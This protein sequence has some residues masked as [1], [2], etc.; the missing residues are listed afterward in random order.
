MIRRSVSCNLYKHLLISAVRHWWLCSASFW[1]QWWHL[2]SKRYLQKKPGWYQADMRDSW[3]KK[4]Y[5]C[6]DSRLYNLVDTD[7]WF[8]ARKKH[9]NHHAFWVLKTMSSPGKKG[10]RTMRKPE[11]A[12]I[13]AFDSL[14]TII[15]RNKPMKAINYSSDLRPVTSYTFSK[16]VHGINRPT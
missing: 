6:T 4:R 14:H 12:W 7:T 3:I 15:L 8:H 16:A 1:L 11:D 5:C 13:Y 9:S 2:L 10:V